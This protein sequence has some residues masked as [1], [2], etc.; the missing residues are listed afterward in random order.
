MVI[1]VVGIVLLS[2]LLRESELLRLL[3]HV[4]CLFSTCIS[5]RITVGLQFSINS[6]IWFVDV[7]HSSISALAV[8]LQ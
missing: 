2:D 6:S 5:G 8:S 4:D 7:V 3:S 1:C